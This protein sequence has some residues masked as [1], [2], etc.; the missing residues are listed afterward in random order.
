[1]VL[2]IVMLYGVMLLACGCSNPLTLLG[3]SSGEQDSTQTETKK[4]KKVALNN[5]KK[6][7][8]ILKKVRSK[9]KTTIVSGYQ[10]MTAPDEENYGL[11]T[12]NRKYMAQLDTMEYQK[13]M[14]AVADYVKKELK[15]DEESVYECIDPR[16]L[17]IY[18]DPDKGVAKGYK[19]ENIWVGEYQ[20]KDGTWKY[21]IAVRKAKEE[22]WKVIH[23]GDSYKK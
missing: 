18:E 3:Q 12:T 7:D 4:V 2:S 5:N 17:K 22:P 16:V 21:I 20:E 19:N 23:H 14:E 11:D 8:K 15:L 9:R 1:M 6:I 10:M 13:A